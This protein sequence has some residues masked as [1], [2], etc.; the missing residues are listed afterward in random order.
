M[1]KRCPYCGEP[2]FSW[3]SQI[4]VD[5]TVETINRR[6]EFGA[7]TCPSCTRN[8]VR[9]VGLCGHYAERGLYLLLFFI[10]PMMAMT[11]IFIGANIIDSHAL[12]VAAFLAPWLTVAVACYFLGHF[13]KRE[14]SERESD[15]RMTVTVAK[16][17]RL[18]SV[19][20]GDVYLAR[21][22][23]RGTTDEAPHLFVIVTRRRKT[24]THTELELRITRVY[25]LDLPAV[26]EP[27]WLITH[28]QRVVEGTVTAVKPARNIG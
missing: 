3:V 6:G 4:G 26:D 24:A 13:D 21:L 7:A 25:G 27:L 28:G 8:A 9:R 22:P 20:I 17:T 23:K 18:P 15:A 12:M 14:K 11:A 5:T 19:R 10:V 16:D 1:K 2:A